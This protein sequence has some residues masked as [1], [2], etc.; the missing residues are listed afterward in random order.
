ME[1]GYH[2]Q[3]CVVTCSFSVYWPIGCWQNAMRIAMATL[4]RLLMQSQ[5]CG[6]HVCTQCIQRF[7][8][9][10][11]HFGWV[12]S[13]MSKDWLADCQPHYMVLGLDNKKRRALFSMY[14]GRKCYAHRIYFAI[15]H[16]YVHTSLLDLGS[17]LNALG[18]CQ[19]TRAS[20][21]DSNWLLRS[22]GNQPGRHHLPAT[23]KSDC[24]PCNNLQG[25][26]SCLAGL[27]VGCLI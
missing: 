13:C 18:Y 16:V 20:Y 9:W 7:E 24:F 3:S 8:H 17:R 4:S 26:G 11:W 14:T 10:R 15:L 1:K 12:C 5:D 6:P 25:G 2:T 22:K 23:H 19:R 27:I 21:M